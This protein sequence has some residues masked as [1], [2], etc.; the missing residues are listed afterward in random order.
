MMKN[1]LTYF[2]AFTLVLSSVSCEDFLDVNVDEDQPSSATPNLLISPIIALMSTNCYEQGETTA[3]FTQQLTTLSGFNSVK[4][5]WDYSSVTRVGLFRRH[6]HDVASNAWNLIRTSQA[7]GSGNYEAIGHIIMVLSTQTAT[8]LFGDM[9]YSEALKGNPSP[10]YDDQ[11]VI[12]DGMLEEI[13]LAIDLLESPDETDRALINDTMFDGDLSNWLAFAHAIKARI[14]LHMTPNVNQ[15]YQPIIDEVDLALSGWADPV[16]DLYDSSANL[17]LVN[18]WGPMAANPEWDYVPNILN[19]SAP[20][21]FFLESVMGFDPITQTINDPR[22]PLLVKPNASG[23]YLSIIASE[24]KNALLEDE[25]YPDL[26]GSYMTRN[27]SEQ[28]FMTI[29][30]LYFIKAEAAFQSGDKGMAFTAFQM[31]VEAHMKRVGVDAV[32]IAAFMS[33]SMVPQSVAEL[34]LSDVMMQ[35]W[36]ALYL[37]AEAWVDMRRYQYDDQVY[38]GLTK[39]ENL[40]VFWSDD[41]TEW[42][43]RIAYDNQTEE[44]Y[45]K[46]ELERLGAFQNPEWLKVKMWWAQ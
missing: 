2:M 32:D 37:Q 46:P 23:E 4:D 40:A 39:P 17:Y 20:T 35:K 10:P 1:I 27:D 28:P 16:F 31:G 26:F 8:D 44:I 43:Q 21:T 11:S 38:P 13:E 41:D 6:F 42:I 5:R 33:S 30:E 9:P 3:Y 45:N 7:E 15:D 22:M 19:S 14:L 25:D 18:Q 34:Q 24:G 29:E 36:L 12:Y